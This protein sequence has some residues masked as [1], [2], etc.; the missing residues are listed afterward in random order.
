[1]AGWVHGR[2]RHG[3]ARLVIRHLQMRSPVPT[4]PVPRAY[5]IR[6]SDRT[7]RPTPHTSGAWS[8]AEQHISPLAGLVVHAIDRLVDDR[9]AR[10]N[11]ADDRAIGRL[12]FD[13]LGV[14][15]IEDF[16]IDVAVVRPGRTVE[17]VEATVTSGPRTV[18]RARAWRLAC[19]DTRG[20][21]G[22]Q[23]PPIARRQDLQSWPMTSVW[24]GG[25][26]ESLDVRRSADSEPG[27]S[28]AWV[29][30]S[31]E[32]LAG[33]ETSPLARFVALV[34]TANGICVRQPPEEWLFPNVDLTIH[35]HRQPA[36]GAVGLDTTVVFG[37]DGHGLTSTVLHDEQGP[38]GEAA[39]ILTIR[40]RRRAAGRAM[41][42][43]ERPAAR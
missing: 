11:R 4:T 26:I 8:E 14:I 10:E 15:G 25:Y 2:P 23:P 33:E 5:F 27:R 29:S 42:G 36:V 16:D 9:A 32:L 3:T 41:W 37:P 1:V 24:P 31:L 7:Y 35:L 30:T 19:A 12:S 39:Q 40:P 6:V 17:L 21:A 20:I 18:L 34:D 38:V 28:T 22:G 13:I 43:M